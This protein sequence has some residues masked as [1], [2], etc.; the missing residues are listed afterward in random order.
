MDL[1]QKRTEEKAGEETGRDSNQQ[2]GGGGTVRCIA[3]RSLRKQALVEPKR[4]SRC[5]R[6]EA[7]GHGPLSVFTLAH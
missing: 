3:T 1:Q 4:S 5:R 6:P 7:S 2:R